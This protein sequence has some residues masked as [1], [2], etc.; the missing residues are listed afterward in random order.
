MRPLVLPS[1][2]V[3]L[4]LAGLPPA[5]AQNPPR[6]APPHAPVQPYKLVTIVPPK[7]IADPG[8]DAFRKQLGE[9]ARR[10]DHAALARLVVAQGFFWERRNGESA[11]K[12]KS[13]IDH[14]ATALG[15]GTKDGVGWDILASYA[16]EP[17][18]SPSADR[19][20]AVCAPADPTFN[21]QELDALLEATKT[22]ITEWGYPVSSTI[23]V[24]TL[25]Q[26]NS[27]VVEK[28]GLAFVRMVAETAPASL[29]YLR[30]VT[31]SGKSGYVSIDSIAPVGSEQLCYVKDDGGWK[32]G[33]FIGDGE[34]H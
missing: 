6:G 34:P 2:V 1:A 8:F 19:K 33:G 12:R 5:L 28:L 31:P 16:D 20:G 18:A 27:P 17:T 3:F 23:E 11:N 26:G 10:K 25:P 30:V 22:D 13:G 4:L 29:A 32:V 15:L 7:L 24:H 14:L 9:A 21:Q